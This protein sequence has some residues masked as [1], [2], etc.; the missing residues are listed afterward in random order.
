MVALFVRNETTAQWQNVTGTSV[1]INVDSESNY[2]ASVSS[3]TRMGD[4]GVLLYITF[5]TTDAGAGWLLKTF[6]QITL[7]SSQTKHFFIMRLYEVSPT[8]WIF[9]FFVSL[10]PGSQN[11]LTLPRMWLLQMRPPPP[12][13]CCGTRLL[14]LMA[15]LYTTLF[16]TLKT[17]L[18]LSRWDTYT[19]YRIYRQLH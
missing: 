2:N 4:G 10:L 5:T 1:V 18:W 13:P 6:W 7:S 14:N 3:W 16:T 11:P 9:V 19:V 8:S 15:L 17:T 12:S